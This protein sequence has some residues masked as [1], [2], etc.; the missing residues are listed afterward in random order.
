MRLFYFLL[1]IFFCV[2]VFAQ[3]MEKRYFKNNPTRGGD[4]T[5]MKTKLFFLLIVGFT[6]ATFSCN[7]DPDNVHFDENN[8]DAST[9]LDSNTPSLER[10]VT[11]NPYLGID[12]N[13][14]YFT[15]EE[16]AQILA[17]KALLPEKLISVFD[18]KLLIWSETWLSYPIALSAHSRDYA[19]SEEYF[20]L[21]NYCKKYDKAL[22]PLMFEQI[23]FEIGYVHFMSWL[24]VDASSPEY[25]SL[26]DYVHNY[27]W[28]NALYVV[29]IRKDDYDYYARYIFKLEYNN[30]LQDIQK[31]LIMEE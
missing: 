14:P 25:Q 6:L 26:Y 29:F 24:L 23:A 10:P 2:S 11:E 3:E 17:L 30:M 31:L 13:N 15:E 7:S 9:H 1:G 21:L 22:W 8:P 19:A 28:R 18:E 20:D 4:K 27:Y 5:N 16:K 12:F